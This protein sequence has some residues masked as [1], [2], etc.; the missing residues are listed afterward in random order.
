[1]TSRRTCDQQEQSFCGVPVGGTQVRL[2]WWAQTERGM[3]GGGGGWRGRKAGYHTALPLME[4][5]NF[6]ERSGKSGRVAAGESHLLDHCSGC[7]ED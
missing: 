1:M 2:P 7:R 5:L 6:L 3:K 4:G